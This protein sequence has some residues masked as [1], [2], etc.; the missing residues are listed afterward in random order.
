MVAL[1]RPRELHSFRL[2]AMLSLIG[3]SAPPDGT[4]IDVDRNFVT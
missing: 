2:V 4:R 1:T 3:E